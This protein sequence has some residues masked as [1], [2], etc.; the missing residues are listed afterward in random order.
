MAQSAGSMHASRPRGIDDN[1]GLEDPFSGCLQR[2]GCGEA[3]IYLLHFVHVHLQ[4]LQ[5]EYK[6]YSCSVRVRACDEK[7]TDKQDEILTFLTV[8]DIVWVV[9]FRPYYNPHRS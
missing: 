6:H 2:L 7:C 1:S 9:L 3:E 8:R 5:P 4:S